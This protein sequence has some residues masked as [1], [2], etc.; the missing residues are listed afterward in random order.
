VEAEPEADVAAEPEPELTV[1]PPMWVR[2]V[3]ERVAAAPAAKPS[4]NDAQAPLL[5]IIERYTLAVAKEPVR[6]I[7]TDLETKLDD[8]ARA[9]REE[10]LASNTPGAT[11]VARKPPDLDTPWLAPIRKAWEPPASEEEQPRPRWAFR[12]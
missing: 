1:E 9:A 6:E 3:R 10:I 11:R 7:D 2:P 12:K 4:S 5:E 8:L